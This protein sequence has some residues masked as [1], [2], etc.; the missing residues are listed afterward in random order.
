MASNN[1]LVLLSLL[2][3]TKSFNS[4]AVNFN[5]G[6]IY[7]EREGLRDPTGRLSSWEV[8]VDCCNW[9]DV[10]CD[11]EMVHVSMLDLRSQYFCYRREHNQA[12]DYNLSCS[13]DTLNPS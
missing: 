10:G 7:K 4:N 8:G 9:F 13:F 2:L 5:L 3:L 12:A 1:L 6:C 11:N